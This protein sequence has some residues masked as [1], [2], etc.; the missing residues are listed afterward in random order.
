MSTRAKATTAIVSALAI[1]ALTLTWNGR[2]AP[3][4]LDSPVADSA[5]IQKLLG[6]QLAYDERIQELTAENDKLREELRA[7]RERAA[8]ER[9]N[10]AELREQELAKNNDHTADASTPSPQLPPGCLL[11]DDL[12]DHEKERCPKPPGQI[13]ERMSDGGLMYFTVWR[14]GKPAVLRGEEWQEVA[15]MY[16][17]WKQQVSLKDDMEDRSVIGPTFDVG[18][19]A[20]AFLKRLQ[21]ERKETR[22]RLGSRLSRSGFV[23]FVVDQAALDEAL[24]TNREYQ[25]VQT[26]FGQLQTELGFHSSAGGGLFYP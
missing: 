17:L 14:E 18:E 7:A 10:R 1:V 6:E 9:S 19:T 12:S 4:G 21:V 20:K 25:Q 13:Y 3:N 8:A 16:D 23:Y 2:T 22:L 15:H 11:Y 26:E 5:Q 24:T